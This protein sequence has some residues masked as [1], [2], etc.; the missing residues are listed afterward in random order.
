MSVTFQGPEY[1]KTVISGATKGG[2]PILRI[3]AWNE[4][5]LAHGKNP[6]DYFFQEWNGATHTIN[7][8]PNGFGLLDSAVQ[9]AEAAGIHLIVCLTK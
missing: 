8:G 5:D 4:K 7:D 3:A 1:V 2:F 6:G 9:Q